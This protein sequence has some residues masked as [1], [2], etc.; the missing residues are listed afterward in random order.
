MRTSSTFSIL[1]WIYSKRT[2]NDQA[3]LYARITVNGKKLNIS[4]K[5]KINVKLWN[6]DK[7]RAK[8]TS[9]NSREINQYISEIHS[10]LFFQCFQELRTNNKRITPQM[11]KSKIFWGRED[12]LYDVRYYRVSQYS[13]V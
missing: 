12:L 4:L 2:K 9:S 1:F 6:A 7:Q 11:I 8:G 5:R 10:Q 3:P 13:Y